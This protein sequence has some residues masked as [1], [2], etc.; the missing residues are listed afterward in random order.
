MKKALISPLRDRW[1]V[2]VADGPD[3]DV[4][5]NLVDHE[6][7]IEDG[8]STVAEVS[9]RW[10][11]VADTYGVEV[12]PGQNPALMLAVTTVLDQMAHEARCH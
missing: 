12:A 7:T 8:G 9:K 4:K 2:K 1:A 10:F 3:L 6:Y 11:R 5:G